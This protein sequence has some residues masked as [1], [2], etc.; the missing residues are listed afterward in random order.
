MKNLVIIFSFFISGITIAQIPNYVPTNGLVGWWPFNGN[1]NDESGN[2]NN[3]TVNGATLTTDRNGVANSAYSFDGVND[4]IDVGNANVLNSN[5]I[6]ISAWYNANDYGSLTQLSQGNLVSKRE[7]SGWGSAYQLALSSNPSNIVYAPYTISGQNGYVSSTTQ[8][9]NQWINVTYVHDIN[10]AKVYING[11]LS[12]TTLVSGGLTAN[13]LPAWFGAR[14]NAGS[15]SHYLNGS[16]DDIGIWNRALTDCE[17]QDLFHAQVGFTTVN[18]G[19]DQSICRGADVTLNG[20]G[21]SSLSW[22]NG[23]VNG[24]AFAPNQTSNYV[25]TGSDSLGCVGTDTVLVTVLDNASSTINQTAI[26]SY[27]LN[28]QT[29]TQS[30]TYTQVLTAANGCDSTITLNLELDFTG[31]QTSNLTLLK[32]YPNPVQDVLHIEGL[33]GKEFEYEVLSIDGKLL[34]KGK[35]QGEIAVKELRKGN[36]VLRVGQQ[37]VSFVKM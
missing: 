34:Q 18:A 3:G 10:S 17:I 20:T 13:N 33:A 28:G 25:L 31:I 8:P 27:T 30:G 21:G 37:Q 1:A 4:Y 22:N 15:L 16:L 24:V 7:Q 9:I 6:S 23:V 36:Y 12:G 11:V 26:D 19:Q 32:L 5:V 29:Y 35:S 14:P 2:G